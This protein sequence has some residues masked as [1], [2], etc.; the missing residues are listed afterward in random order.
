MKKLSMK[1]TGYFMLGMSWYFRKISTV[2][3][4]SFV[5]IRSAVFEKVHNRRTGYRYQFNRYSDKANGKNLSIYYT[6][7]IIS[8]REVI[9]ILIW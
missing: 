7:I 2:G 3:S 1:L 8:P 4:P 9:I 6:T 5:S